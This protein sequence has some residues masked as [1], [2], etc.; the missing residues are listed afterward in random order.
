MEKPQLVKV[1]TRLKQLNEQGVRYSIPIKDALEKANYRGGVEGFKNLVRSG[2]DNELPIINYILNV[3]ETMIR[4]H[5][6]V[7]ANSRGV[8][9]KSVA[10]P[11]ELKLHKQSTSETLGL[12]D[13]GRRIVLDAHNL[14]RARYGARPLEYDRQLEI[15]AQEWANHLVVIPEMKH[16]PNKVCG[17][18][19]GDTGENIAREEGWANYEPRHTTPI[20]DWHSEVK[21][22]D[23]VK[24][25][26]KPSGEWGHFTQLIWKST[27]KVG[28]GFVLLRHGHDGF[29]SAWVCTYHPAGNVPGEFPANT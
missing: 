10:P 6:A 18:F 25:V 21:N 8:S 16:N 27:R 29:R 12:D 20:R 13:Q 1:G 26:P 15:K 7:L 17:G 5:V 28:C 9:P 2:N 11:K 24:K 3:W 19:V 14:C 22:Y 23:L 4:D